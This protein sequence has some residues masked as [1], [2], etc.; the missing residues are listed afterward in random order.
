MELIDGAGHL[1]MLEKPL[2]LSQAIL[3]FLGGL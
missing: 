2:A 3:N 1:V